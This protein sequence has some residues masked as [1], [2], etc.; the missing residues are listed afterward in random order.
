[1]KKFLTIMALLVVFVTTGFAEGTF[2][3]VGGSTDVFGTTW[4]TGNTDNDMTLTNEVYILK[5]SVTLAA[6]TTLEYKVVKNHAWGDGECP[7]Q[8]NLSVKL[9]A[10]T[11][12]VVFLFNGS[13][14]LTAIYKTQLLGTWNWDTTKTPLTLTSDDG[15]V[16]TGELDLSTTVEDQKFKFVTNQGT[17]PGGAWF[18][19]GGAA[20]VSAPDGWISNQTD[21]DYNYILTNSTT[22]Y[23]KYTITATWNG[24]WTITIAGKEARPKYTYTATFVNGANW[25]NVY[26]YIWKV[27]GDNNV[28][29]NGDYPGQKLVKSGTETISTVEYDVYTFTFETYDA[30]AVPEY[31]IF[32]DG[33]STNQTENLAFV[34]EK[35]YTETVPANAT[36]SL[37]LIHGAFAS[38]TQWANALTLPLTGS[39]NVYSQTVP[40]TSTLQ[41]LVFEL[42]V[43]GQNVRFNDVTIDPESTTGLLVDGGGNEHFILFKNSI[44]GY[45]TYV[46]TATWTPNPDPK[47]G[48]T[49][50]VVGVHE[51]TLDYAI[52]GDLTGG[53]PATTD[54]D[55][56][57]DVSMT[58][59][60]NGLYTL[61]VNEFAAE[62]NTTYE[63]KLRTNKMWNLFDLP[64]NGNASWTPTEAGNYKLTF[65]ANV[66][67][68]AITDETFGE[69]P[70]YTVTVVPE[71]IIVPIT[72]YYIVTKG[73]NN[74]WTTKAQMTEN[75]GVF[76]Y[77][78]TGKYNQGVI[79]NIVPN[80]ALNNDLT[81]VDTWDDVYVPVSSGNY[82]VEFKDYPE[83]SLEKTS[84]IVGFIFK[85]SGATTTITYNPAQ[86][87]DKIAIT[88]TAEATVSEAG[89]ATYSNSWDYKVVGNG[90]KVYVVKGV[91][92]GEADMVEL[93]AGAGIPA[94]TGVV[95]E[96]DAGSYTVTPAEEAT[97]DVT[98]NLLVGSGDYVYGISGDFGQGAN[99]RY[100]TAYILAKKGTDV[101]FYKFD[102]SDGIV[103]DPHKAFLAVP[104]NGD[105]DAPAFIGFGDTT[106]IVNVNRETITNNQYYTLDGRRVENPTKGLY[107][108]NGKKVVIK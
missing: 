28:K 108:V 62:A 77:T 86:N 24:S 38:D 11:Y 16:W 49:L 41:D 91:A 59:Q 36:I 21:V 92:D 2:T 70:A 6:E 58:A 55:G 10:G 69:I 14:K 73:D 95:I 46:A 44:S 34:D 30:T 104:K 78:F 51:R 65:V 74:V 89:Y 45:D 80:T 42:Q 105:S 25:E 43:N 103:L 1:M 88:N 4:D 100:Y 63:Y 35:E 64:G 66:T 37:V 67:G 97:A 12:D 98:G 79:F 29:L 94:Y 68:T 32:S 96:A 101:G 106:G 75:E 26:A 18:G 48:W 72:A 56:S 93:A 54:D 82:W 47:A 87:V 90:L 9:P 23:Q 8:G 71:K 85:A 5:K 39:E 52:V 20:T 53:W 40:L 57:K 15:V 31:I 19:Y 7:S 50:K 84:N 3:V 13:D 27:D 99:P 22:D 76:T 102:S 81:Q 60:N 83:I 17:E 61:V 107:I 33:T